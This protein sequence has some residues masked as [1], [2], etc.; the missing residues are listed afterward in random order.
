MLILKLIS[1]ENRRTFHRPPR[2]RRAC[3]KTN[4]SIF[5]DDSRLARGDRLRRLAWRGRKY[6]RLYANPRFGILRRRAP[7]PLVVESDL[8]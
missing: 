6:G 4:L 8:R 3:G 1:P 7:A 5:T 2:F